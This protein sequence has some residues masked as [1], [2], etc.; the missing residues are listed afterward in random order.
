MQVHAVAVPGS[1]LGGMVSP[2]LAHQHPR[3]GS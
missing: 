1:W 2:R 3:G